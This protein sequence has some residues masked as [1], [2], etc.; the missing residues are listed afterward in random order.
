MIREA[1]GFEATVEA[2]PQVPSAAFIQL[3]VGTDA[4]C[5][6]AAD[7][8][9]TCWPRRAG[10]EPP[11]PPSPAKQIAV[12]LMGPC[13]LTDSGA[14]TCTNDTLATLAGPFERLVSGASLCALRAEGGGAC[15]SPG[16]REPRILADNVVDYQPGRTHDC[17]LQGDGHLACS[18][19]G[20]AAEV[21]E[22]GLPYV[23]VSA[24]ASQS[25]ALRSDDRLLCV[26]GHRGLISQGTY[27]QVSVGF[28]DGCGLTRDGD[29]RCWG[30]TEE[31]RTAAPKGRFE[32]IAT[33]QSFACALDAKGAISCWGKAGDLGEKLRPPRGSFVEL[34]LGQLFGCAR[35]ADGSVA[36]W[37]FDL[38]GETRVPPGPWAELETGG[39]FT[40]V[41]DEE[42]RATCV[43]FGEGRVP[44]AEARWR[45]FSAGDRH[46]CGVTVDNITDCSGWSSV[47]QT[48]R[49]P[50]DRV[51]ALAA[52]G[53]QTCAVLDDGALLCWGSPLVYMPIAPR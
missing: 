46:W 35:A 4:A 49:P 20:T 5:G 19:G 16:E 23:S 8:K 47:G 38:H 39:A 21:F 6:L 41:L 32:A 3:D 9:V 27:R 22:P 13:A 29:L 1:H 26:G 50:G 10:A 53:Y 11:T 34:D 14:V 45:L 42:R 40:C 33:G 37:G 43:G 48:W 28:Y 30:Q 7:G 31:L 24:G 25:C 17:A 15:W 44:D 51:R 2:L 18:G 52:G 12:G 36:C